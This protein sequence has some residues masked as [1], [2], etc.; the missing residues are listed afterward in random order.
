MMPTASPRR[1]LRPC[2]AGPGVLG[3]PIFRTV[4]IRERK[5]AERSGRPLV[6]V[7][8]TL[9]PRHRRSSPEAAAAERLAAATESTDVVGWYEPGAVIGIVRLLTIAPEAGLPS[10]AAG[11]D[12][13]RRLAARLE[14][15]VAQGC[16]VR[17]LVYPEPVPPTTEELGTIDPTLYPELAFPR[18]RERR[19]DAAKR[20]LDAVASLLLLVVLAPAI[21]VIAVLV[22]LTSPGPAFFGQTRI[23]HM[24]RP[25]TVL[26]FR[27]MYA[28]ADSAV[29]EEFVS[30]FIA[31]GGTNGQP[32]VDGL[33]KL[34]QDRRVTRLGRFLRKT[35]L[36]ELPQLWNVLRGEMSLVGPRPPVPYEYAQYQPWHRRRVIDTKP[37][38]TG[39]WQVAGRSRTT[40][41]EM[42]RLDLRYARTRSLRRDLAIICRTPPAVISG[43]GAC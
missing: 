8:L 24:R 32:P 34:T 20:T 27:T 23:G 43:K 35:S 31:A 5:R 16:S 10:S 17:V 13:G 19:R 25:F 41:D 4:L 40:F 12:G 28:H 37:G 26:K 21:A 18:R 14:Q 36:D 15:E 38:L 11:A 2:Q 3:A 33:F 39:L 29:H 9:P 42:V 1:S 22:K 7:L 6:L 30:R